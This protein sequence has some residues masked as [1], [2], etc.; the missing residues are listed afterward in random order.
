MIEWDDFDYETPELGSES[1]EY[2]VSARNALEQFFD[3]N[4]SGVF[5]G[6]QLAVQNEDVFFHWITYRAIA[7]LID[8]GLIHTERRKMAIGSEIKLVWHRKHRYYK[9]DAKR[10]V[11]LVDEYG[12]PNICAAMGLH[13][14]QMILG[15]FARKQ[16]VMRD[17]NTRRFLDREWNE[18]DH[19]LDFIFE[20]DGRA[21]GV[22]VKNTLSYMDRKEFEIKIRLCE[23][24]GITPVFAV[25]M[26]P[27]SWIYELISRGWICDDSE[28]SVVSVDTHQL[29][30]QGSARA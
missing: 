10:V 11:D 21:Y 4:S 3:A 6:N 18:T 8:A 30:S 28:V 1:D 26:L 9:R 14:E 5:F 15:G 22:E 27:K 23:A 19:N 25:R 20:R 7:D 2:E 29:G 24:L 17:H 13:G 12:S 16:F